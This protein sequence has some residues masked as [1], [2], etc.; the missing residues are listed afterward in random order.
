MYLVDGNNVMGQRVGWHR[1]KP[2]AQRRL[3][4]ELAEMKRQQD[5]VV[6]VVF[7][8]KPLDGINDGSHVD[9][10]TVYFARPW[11]D[12]DERIVE[13]ARD[14][15]EP[16]QI[17]AVTS[18]RRLNDQLEYLGVRTMRSGR[19]RKLLEKPSRQSSS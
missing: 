4:L 3:L 13:L 6:T 11:S 5:V 19:F 8:G 15:P 7:D 18:D 14:A 10:V 9:G 12:A 16:E 2:E 17:L 1:N